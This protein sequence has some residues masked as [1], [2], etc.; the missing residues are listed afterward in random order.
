MEKYFEVR[1]TR[2]FEFKI[3]MYVKTEIIFVLLKNVSN[4]LTN[5]LF[6]KPRSQFFLKRQPI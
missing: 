1:K 2:V 3:K 6:Y 5:D 4:K